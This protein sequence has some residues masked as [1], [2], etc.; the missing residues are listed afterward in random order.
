MVKAEAQQIKRQAGR[1]TGQPMS[2]TLLVLVPCLSASYEGLREQASAE[3][4]LV[5]GDTAMLVG[6]AGDV[7]CLAAHD[8]LDCEALRQH[9]GTDDPVVELV[10][11]PALVLPPL[12][13]RPAGVLLPRFPYGLDDPVTPVLG[14]SD[15]HQPREAWV[16]LELPEGT[17]VPPGPAQAHLLLRPHPEGVRVEPFVHPLGRD[18]LVSLHPGL[19]AEGWASSVLPYT[20]VQ[21]LLPLVPA[22]ISF[23]GADERPFAE[24]TWSDTPPSLQGFELADTAWS[25]MASSSLSL[26]T[27]ACM[28]AYY[29]HYRRRPG[30]TPAPPIDI[31]PP[32]LVIDLDPL[33]QVRDAQPLSKPWD[34]LEPASCLRANARLLP[35][36]RQGPALTIVVPSLSALATE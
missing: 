12:A 2:T 6:L 20:G 19:L 22:A 9:P 23:R 15:I 25:E 35:P 13:G 34:E 31:D 1:V 24:A 21:V 27:G 16:L 26:A 18:D 32:V 7:G 30:T 4:Q 10:P 28:R 5:A 17:V 8:P 11:V 36:A 3:G 29:G 14:A 33:G